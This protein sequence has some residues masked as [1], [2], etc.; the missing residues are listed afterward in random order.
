MAKQRIPSTPA[1]RDLRH[2]DIAF[3]PFLYEYEEAGGTAQFAALFDVPEHLVVK[4]LVL[5]DDTGAPFLVL[6]HGDRTV[7]MK[8]MARVRGVKRCAMSDPGTAQRHT[9]YLVGGTSPFGTR[10][11]LPIY[12]QETI[13]DLDRCF[14]N[15]GSRGFIVGLS[16]ADLLRVLD[17]VLADLGTSEADGDSPEHGMES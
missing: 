14:V 16:A 15:G 3:E 7:S 4:T 17:P 12:A 9:S 5:E 2:H 10:K 8:A 1:V 6:M 13:G 11:A